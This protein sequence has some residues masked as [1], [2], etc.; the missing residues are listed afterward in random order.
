MSSESDDVT[1]AKG[2]LAIFLL[3][4][5]GIVYFFQYKAEFDPSKEHTSVHVGIGQEFKVIK[6][7]T[8]D[9]QEVAFKVLGV[10]HVYKK[11]DTVWYE[12]DGK[13]DR[14]VTNFLGHPEIKGIFCGELQTFAIAWESDSSRQTVHL[15]VLPGFRIEPQEE[16]QSIGLAL[17]LRTYLLFDPGIP[18]ILGSV[19]ANLFA[20]G[21]CVF[22]VVT[23]PRFQYQTRKQR[24]LTLFGLLGI[25]AGVIVFLI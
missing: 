20:M 16:A 7:C 24:S 9:K 2:V 8:G 6:G 1:V 13:A 4:I 14:V 3:I 18:K 10:D 17:Q 21:C 19:L 11:G 25:V 12:L 15:R 22:V 5:A 23:Q